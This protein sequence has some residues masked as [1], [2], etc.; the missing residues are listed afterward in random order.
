MPFL[1]LERRH[2]RQCAEAR[3]SD[4]ALTDDEVKRV[5]D[6]M[7]FWPPDT[8]LFSQTGCKRVAQKVDMVL[9][10]RYDDL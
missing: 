8:L 7:V 10:E 3:G 1:P 4:R 2:V 9:E 5:L 6:E